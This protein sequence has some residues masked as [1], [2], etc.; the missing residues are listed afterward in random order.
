[1]FIASCVGNIYTSEDGKVWAGP[2]PVT[3]LSTNA[4]LSMAI[5]GGTIY[6]GGNWFCYSSSD[7]INWVNEFS[8]GTVI[9]GMA[10]GN[11]ILV[12]V[13]DSGNIRTRSRAGS[14]FSTTAGGSQ[15]MRAA[16]GNGVF[17]A[18]GSDSAAVSVNEG[19]SWS[20]LT[21]NNNGLA[22]STFVAFGDGYFA[23]GAADGTIRFSSNGIDWSS[24]QAS[25]VPI[26]NAYGAIEF[27]A[28]KWIVGGNSGTIGV[29]Q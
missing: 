27:F 12:G 19:L 23:A 29:S 8:P 15:L 4:A 24:G 2:I 1:M 10:A 5:T 28:G 20:I 22:G 7:G 26:T 21:A 17:V 6:L 11:G 3:L 14:W 16:Y 25:T 18:V 9:R 13:C